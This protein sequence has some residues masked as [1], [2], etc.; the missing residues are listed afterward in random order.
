VALGLGTGSHVALL[1]KVLFAAEHAPPSSPTLLPAPAYNVQHRVN[2]ARHTT[3]CA[4]AP[5]LLR[6]SAARLL[7]SS[8][9]R[10]LRC[11]LPVS[12]AAINTQHSTKPPPAPFRSSP[13]SPAC[14]QLVLSAINALRPGLLHAWHAEQVPRSFHATFAVRQAQGARLGG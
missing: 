1:H 7:R 9:A 13:S 12:S 11:P 2:H 14:V 5:R 3:R 8:A 10:L 4:H 6:S